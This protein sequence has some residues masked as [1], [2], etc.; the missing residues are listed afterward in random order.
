MVGSVIVVVFLLAIVAL[1]SSKLSFVLFGIALTIFLLF[2][3]KLA[4]LVL[5]LIIG[6][7]VWF[8]SNA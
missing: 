8:C 1:K 5:L 2:L 4:G 7:L 6:A 3:F